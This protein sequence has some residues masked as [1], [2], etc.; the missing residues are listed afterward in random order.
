MLALPEFRPLTGDDFARLD[1]PDGPSHHE[2]MIKI[3]LP[4]RH[5][6]GVTWTWEQQLAEWRRLRV[7]I[8][9]ASAAPGNM[10]RLAFEP[11]SPEARSG[12]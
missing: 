6:M 8:P 3:V 10:R 9:D 1:A 12:H 5:R 4:A 2:N 11:G 7:P